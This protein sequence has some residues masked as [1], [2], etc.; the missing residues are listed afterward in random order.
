MQAFL[1]AGGRSRRMGRDKAGLEL[2]GKPLVVHMLDKFA[3]LGLPATLCGNRSDLAVLAPVLPDPDLRVEE[4]AGPLAGILAALEASKSPL[5][6]FLAV[7]IPGVPINL[8]RWMI[9]RAQR[10]ES[11]ATIPFVSGRPQ[12]LCSVYHR[13]LAPEVRRSLEAGERRVFPV[14]RQA[15]S[16]VGTFDVESIVSAGLIEPLPP[17]FPHEW[18]HNLNTPQEFA[19]YA[20]RQPSNKL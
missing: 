20:S 10:T 7:D 16:C 17:G 3:R 18:F 1:L 5:N 8:L 2:A 13:C 4:S 14:L 19:L 15:A 9:D 12:P 6:L 11:A